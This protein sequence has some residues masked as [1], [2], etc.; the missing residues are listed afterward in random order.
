[1]LLGCH[2]LTVYSP[3]GQ[4]VAKPDSWRYKLGHEFRERA[5][6]YQPDIVLQHPHNTD[7]PG[8]WRQAW[9]QLSNQLPSVKHYASGIKYY[10][11]RQPDNKRA[12][13]EK[14]L[15]GTMMGDV[16]EFY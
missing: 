16:K 4:A 1:M 10:N 7:T 11:N 2:D 9:S 3:R 8:T 14:V 15:E 5:K 13:L 12:T 6:T